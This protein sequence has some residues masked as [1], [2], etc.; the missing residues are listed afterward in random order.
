MLGKKK[1]KRAKRLR[2][3]AVLGKKKKTEGKTS[4]WCCYVGEEEEDGLIE[5]KGFESNRH[6]IN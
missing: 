6:V 1:K 3:V 2:G 5:G 4:S